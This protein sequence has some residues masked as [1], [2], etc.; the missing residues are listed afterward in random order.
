MDRTALISSRPAAAAPAYTS[1]LSP[2]ESR[3][4]TAAAAAQGSEMMGESVRA[5][6]VGGEP[7]AFTR[8][9]QG[10]EQLQ[11]VNERLGDRGFG[12]TSLV[13]E[14]GVGRE[15]V[16]AAGGA[17]DREGFGRGSD[18]AVDDVTDSYV[19]SARETAAEAALGGG[20]AVRGGRTMEGQQYSAGTYPAV[21]G[22]PAGGFREGVTAGEGAGLGGAAPRVSDAG[23]YMQDSSYAWE[24]FVLTEFAR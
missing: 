23:E 15:R 12:S 2:P 16:R 6:A 24:P 10:V 14:E 9:Q 22:A 3:G 7:A 19:P 4:V 13:E 8:E 17:I 21:N 20:T 5:A 11:P 1:T 18:P